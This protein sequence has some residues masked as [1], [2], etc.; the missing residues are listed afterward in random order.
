MILPRSAT[1][2][3]GGCVD[4]LLSRVACGAN[5]GWHV[6][7]ALIFSVVT[8][9]TAADFVVELLS[10]DTKRTLSVG[11]V[12]SGLVF[13]CGAVS[14]S[15]RIRDVLFTKRAKFATVDNRRSGFLVW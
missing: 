13:A 2:A 6:V 11:S 14:A 10:S 9:I 5:C 7:G 3:V 4:V 1:N 15:K 8:S 12:I